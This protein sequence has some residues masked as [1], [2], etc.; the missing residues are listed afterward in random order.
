MRC[1]R[2]RSFVPA[3]VVLISLSVP[4]FTAHARGANPLHKLW[5]GVRNVVTAPLEVPLAIGNPP[6][7]LEP[8]SG[9]GYGFVSGFSRF[10][11]REV[12]GIIETATFL[13]PAYD[14]PMYP[15]G[16]GEPVLIENPED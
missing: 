10:F 5:R 3:V 11:V 16:L 8:V 14:K 9:V 2:R 13:I 7:R 1:L 4:L 12:A 15:A 6:E